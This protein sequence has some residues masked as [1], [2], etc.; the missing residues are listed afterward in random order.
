LGISFD[1]ETLDADLPYTPEGA[2]AV[3]ARGA[4]F[5]GYGA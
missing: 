2:A 3:P 4:N 1:R 5:A